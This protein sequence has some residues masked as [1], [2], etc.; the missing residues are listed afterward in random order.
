VTTLT[1]LALVGAVGFCYLLGAAEIP[2]TAASA[3]SIFALN[4]KGSIRC[5][6]IIGG[7]CPSTGLSTGDGA[8]NLAALWTP[9]TNTGVETLNEDGIVIGPK[10]FT[11]TFT[12]NTNGTFTTTWTGS[13]LGPQKFYGALAGFS[14]G[15]AKDI[16]AVTT[17]TFDSAACDGNAQ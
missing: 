7:K 12:L 17:D 3:Q 1:K 4:C 14:S 9:S 16:R 11:S 13:S 8:F 6:K 2:G 5:S 15:V 10:T